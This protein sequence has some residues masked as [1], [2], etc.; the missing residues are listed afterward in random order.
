MKIER[1]ADLVLSAL[2]GLQLLA[3]EFS[4]SSTAREFGSSLWV[5][6]V[7]DA[8]CAWR[9]VETERST[10]RR[11]RRKRMHCFRSLDEILHAVEER[12][13][14]AAA[15]ELFRA[16]HMQT[17]AGL[18]GVT[19]DWVPSKDFDLIFATSRGLLRA[20]ICRTPSAQTVMLR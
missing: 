11:V 4:Q 9:L 20:D 1:E 12:L 5:A 8:A 18:P 17:V 16:T 19:G 14:W 3:V 13:A 6:F 2:A 15:D 7:A 10:S